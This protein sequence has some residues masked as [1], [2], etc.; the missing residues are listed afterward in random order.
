MLSKQ[1]DRWWM[2]LATMM[3]VQEAPYFPF[4]PYRN[5]GK[6]TGGSLYKGGPLWVL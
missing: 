1:Q 5:P 4:Q 3:G 6:F 2:K